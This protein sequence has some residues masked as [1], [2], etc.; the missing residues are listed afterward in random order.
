MLI[1]DRMANAISEQVGREYGAS[2]QYRMIAAYFE[3][4]AL[5]QLLQ[6]FRQQSDEEHAHAVK[7]IDYVNEAGGVIRIPSIAAGRAEFASIEEAVQIALDSEM[8]LTSYINQL[9]DLAIEEHDHLARGMLQWFVDEQLEEVSLMSD[10]LT[11]EQVAVRQHPL[12]RGLCRTATCSTPSRVGTLGRALRRARQ[13][14]ASVVMPY[15]TL[16]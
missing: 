8:S 14:A 2:I 3:R 5:P 15:E 10:L 7:F 1:S 9:Y 4:E 6:M 11:V 12:H 13:T 16:V